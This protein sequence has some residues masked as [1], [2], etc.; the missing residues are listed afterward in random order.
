MTVEGW[1]YEPGP[2][3]ICR[4]PDRLLVTEDDFKVAVR[5]SAFSTALAWT[6]RV[7]LLG[8]PL[9]WLL[10]VICVARSERAEELSRELA[11]SAVV[12][13]LPAAGLAWVAAWSVSRLRPPPVFSRAWGPPVQ[14]DPHPIEILD[15]V[16][17][18]PTEVAVGLGAAA[19][20]LLTVVWWR[21]IGVERLARGAVLPAAGCESVR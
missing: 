5:A 19:V 10:A 2:F 17:L 13:S 9:L 11:K 4:G 3:V 6:P 18:F 21:A 1:N 15:Q 12:A 14:A 20:V 7:A 8:I 16:L